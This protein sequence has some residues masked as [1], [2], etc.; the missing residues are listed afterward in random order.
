M[1]MELG[2]MVAVMKDKVRTYIQRLLK[3]TPRS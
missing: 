1:A 2:T 3:T